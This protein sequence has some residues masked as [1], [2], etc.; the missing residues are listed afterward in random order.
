[1]TL[2][3]FLARAAAKAADDGAFGGSNAVR[4]PRTAARASHGDPAITSVDDDYWTTTETDPDFTRSAGDGASGEG[5]GAGNASPATAHFLQKA[6]STPQPTP[7]APSFRFDISKEA[8][9]HNAQLLKD[10]EYNLAACLG[11]EQGTPLQ[12]GSEFRDPALLSPLVGTHPL[13]PR[14]EV[15]YWVH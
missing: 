10:T 1:L 2:Q 7:R 4:A 9:E 5:S 6:I 8:A 11:A 14:V 15:V 13:W 12:P 3:A